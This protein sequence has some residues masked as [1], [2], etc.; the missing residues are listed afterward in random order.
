MKSS[1]CKM[2]RWRD[3]A[4][5]QEV[6]DFREGAVTPKWL[7]KK[8][9][10]RGTVKKTAVP[11]GFGECAAETAVQNVDWKRRDSPG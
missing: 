9:W 7:D 5:G 3:G 8:I 2:E 11:C 6:V 4:S 10:F 1:E